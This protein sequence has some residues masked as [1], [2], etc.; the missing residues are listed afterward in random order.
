[1]EARWQAQGQGPL[2]YRSV[3]L[4]KA[5]LHAYRGELREAQETLQ[6][7]LPG[8][9]PYVL[10]ETLAFAAERAHNTEAAGQLYAQAFAYAPP[11][12]RERLRPMLERYGQE[13][14]AL[15]GR[16][17]PYAT[18][19][20]SAVLL[21]LYG[22]QLWAGSRYG[23]NVW[24]AAAGFL[25]LAP[26]AP[27]GEALWRFLSYAFV[28]GGLLHIAMNVWV[29]LDIGR[30]YEARRPWGNVLAAFTVGAIMGAYL[31]FVARDSLA[32][33]G[34]IGA[35]GGVLGIGGALFA[36]V[37]RGQGAQD[38]LLMRSLLQWI[39]FIVIFSIAIPGI[40]LLGHV[41]GLIGGLLWGFMRQGL[42]KSKA[43]DLSA[44]V[45]SIALL[46]YALVGSV[47]W[48]LTYGPQM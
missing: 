13:V 6:T 44:G 4:S 36:D 15:P 29:L 17:T 30:L 46:L 42:P 32:A 33:G 3:T 12:Y 38:R 7:P 28:H 47:S 25:T 2:G 23:E 24:A 22:L 18:Y 45:L 21:L 27:G 1:M 34:V 39:G 48:L 41:G 5:R 40:S 19:V 20:L 37:L 16:S 14:P 10:L 35:S 11:S 43:V 8:V 9:P 31:T 26:G